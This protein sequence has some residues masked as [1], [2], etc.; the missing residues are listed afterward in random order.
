M[1]FLKLAIFA[2]PEKAIFLSR[3]WRTKKFSRLQLAGGFGYKFIY[4]FIVV[5]VSHIDDAAFV[6]T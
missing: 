6:G 2:N 3:Y 1:L 5:I 4:V